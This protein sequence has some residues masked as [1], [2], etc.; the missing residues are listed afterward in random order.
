MT[1]RDLLAAIFSAN[2]D[3]PAIAAL[4]GL[5]RGNDR[6]AALLIQPLPNPVYLSSGMMYAEF[7]P[8]IVSQ[9]RQDF[10]KEKAALEKRCANAKNITSRTLETPANV[11]GADTAVA[12]RHADLTIMVRPDGAPIA[13][14]RRAVFEEVLFGSGRPV[15]LVPPGW[16]PGVIGRNIVI[17][18]NAKREAARAL[19]DAMPFVEAAD[20]VAVVTVD[21]QPSPGGH[22]AHPGADITAHLARKGVS[23]TLRNVDGLGREEGEALLADAVAHQADLLVIGGYGKTR[24]REFVFGGVTRTLSRISSLPLL[25]SH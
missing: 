24:M 14:E 4:E 3:E 25:L 13:D 23:A 5:L 21:A 11:A 6:G 9:A 2:D 19:A 12:A 16:R 8:E 22:G 17:G 15:L 10:A 1:N 20:Q 7:W 18:W